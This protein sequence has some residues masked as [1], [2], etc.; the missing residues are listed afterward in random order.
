MS[1][2]SIF[3]SAIPNGQDHFVGFDNSET[4]VDLSGYFSREELEGDTR[5]Y[6][7]RLRADA[8]GLPSMTEPTKPMPHSLDTGCRAVDCSTTPTQKRTWRMTTRRRNRSG[9]RRHSWSSP[10]PATRMAIGESCCGG[11]ITM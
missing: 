10:G 6:D 1:D 9:C 4:G 3:S 11:M 5:D 8:N 7:V 2:H